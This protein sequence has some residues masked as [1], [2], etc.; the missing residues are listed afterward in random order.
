MTISFLHPLS[1]RGKIVFLGMKALAVT[2]ELVERASEHVENIILRDQIYR[3]ALDEKQSSML[4]TTAEKL[5]Q[6]SEWI[7]QNDLPP[8]L[9]REPDIR[10]ALRL[11]SGSKVIHVPS[12]L[13]GLWS[14][15]E[16]LGSD[17][18]S[19]ELD[20]KCVSSSFDW[21]QKLGAF[22]CVVLAAGSGLIGK[23]VEESELPVTLVRGQAVELV[24]KDIQLDHAM[25]GGKY[26][27]PL[28]DRNRI[29]IGEMESWLL[30]D[31]DTAKKLLP[32]REAP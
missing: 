14:V 5:P 23:L 4:Q 25:L 24:A 26:V 15:C 7:G 17:R 29:L 32:T 1:P 19:W 30:V 6:V 27:S 11:H 12:Y 3:L 16:S 22:D 10:G 28:P 8:Q 20:K 13:K 9:Q 2:N 18:I 31:V 21:K